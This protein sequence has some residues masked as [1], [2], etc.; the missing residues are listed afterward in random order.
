LTIKITR[1]PGIQ[2]MNLFILWTLASAILLACIMGIIS[3]TKNKCK[4]PG[5]AMPLQDIQQI[6]DP[7]VK[8]VQE[9]QSMEQEEENESGQ[10]RDKKASE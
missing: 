6:C 10:D 1:Y 8:H 4:L 5:H 9:I 7:G 3:V 2:Y